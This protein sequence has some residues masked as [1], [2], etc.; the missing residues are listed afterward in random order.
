MNSTA[1]IIDPDGIKCSLE[2]TMTLRDWKLIRKTLSS[3]AAY[4]EVQVM[5]EISDL[6][7]QL[8]KTFYVEKDKG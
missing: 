8:E 7:C 5:N 6:I 1:K 3:N 4:A 2:F